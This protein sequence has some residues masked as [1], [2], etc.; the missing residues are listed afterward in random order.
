MILSLL[1]GLAISVAP[2]FAARAAYVDEASLVAAE[3]EICALSHHASDS[4]HRRE[5]SGCCCLQATTRRDVTF[6]VAILCGVAK[7]AAPDTPSF[8]ARADATRRAGVAL[9][10][11][12]WLS[13]APPSF[14]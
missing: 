14:S 5:G 6:F 1:L 4:D 9:P 13:R 2:G 12:P 8:A 10:T 3:P 7:F 11:T